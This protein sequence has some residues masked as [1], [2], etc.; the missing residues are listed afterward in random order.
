MFTY[1]D[2]KTT[3]QNAPND[4][5][6]VNEEPSHRI[7]VLREIARRHEVCYEVS[8][9]WSIFDGRRVQTGFHLELCGM[10]QHGIEGGIGHSVPGCS[11][12]VGTYEQM[13][14]IAKWI[15]PRVDKRLGYEIQAFDRALHIAPPKR[16]HRCEVL[17]NILITH[18]SDFA[19]CENRCLAEMRQRLSQL[20]IHERPF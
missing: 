10:N 7:Q 1:T 19:D 4:N 5:V 11:S 18:P 2:S 17:V 8:P 12:C 13:R 6:F 15:L 16:N 3:T 20:G 9:Q 14:Q